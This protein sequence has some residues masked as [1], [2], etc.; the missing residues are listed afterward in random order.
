M[1]YADVKKRMLEL[2]EERKR[3]EE[4]AEALIETL[5]APGQNGTPPVGLTGNLVDAEGFPRADVDLF[6]IR[7]HRN[8]LACLK[9]DRKA[10]E[11][12]IEETLLQLHALMASGEGPKEDLDEEDVP[13][14]SQSKPSPVSGNADKDA[15]L[16]PFALVDEVLDGS[17]AK[18]SGIQPGDRILR[19]GSLNHPVSS[20]MRPTLQEIAHETNANMNSAIPV[21][22]QRG[23]ERLGF[24]LT[25]HPWSGQ[26]SL[27]CHIVSG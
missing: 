15:D 10:A 20:S 5:N 7:K 26:G 18:E 3:I 19:F 16:V 27:G 24:N 12:K 21:L 25:P 22:V 23:S 8:R 1:S 4:E 11:K 14:S 17:P 9:T 6:A 2:V 13:E